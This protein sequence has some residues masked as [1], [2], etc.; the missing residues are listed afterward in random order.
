MEINLTVCKCKNMKRQ[1]IQRMSLFSSIIYQR[2]TFRFCVLNHLR[3]N[4]NM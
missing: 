1:V 2:L 3:C 4:S